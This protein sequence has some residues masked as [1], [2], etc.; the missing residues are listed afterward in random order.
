MGLDTPRGERPSRHVLLLHGVGGSARIWSLQLC[1][2]RA[3]GLE[4]IALDL[5]GYAGRP[6]PPAMDFEHLAADVEV[7]L[8][9]LSVLSPVLIGH[10]MGGMLAQTL[11]RRRPA[12]YAA[13][14]LACTSPAFGKA[15]GALQGAFIVDRLAPL[16]RGA[17]MQELALA[18]VPAL[19]GPRA[20]PAGRALA[21]EVMGATPQSTYRAAIRC[22]TTFDERANLPEL[23]L[24]VLCLAGAEDQTAPAPMMERMASK[25]SGARFVVLAGVGHLANVEAPAAFTAAVLDFLRA[26][27][28]L[29]RC[30]RHA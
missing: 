14:V 12:A 4:P 9:R 29:P 23:R 18:M 11:L 20:D 24:P 27:A 15:D 6:L 5:P 21:L 17:T 10:S 19:M 25:I 28:L 1:P 13:A 2:L 8:A 16:D 26:C 7:E 22:L 3:A 30:G